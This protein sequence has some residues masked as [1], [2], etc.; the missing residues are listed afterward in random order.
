MSTRNRKPSRAVGVGG[1]AGTIAGTL[2]EVGAA[3]AGVPL[4]P[5]SGA[6]LGGALATLF[7]YIT[8][9]G[10]RGESD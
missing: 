3:A 2:I 5:G 8:R 4:P 6:A 9:G 7:A 10:R 1:T